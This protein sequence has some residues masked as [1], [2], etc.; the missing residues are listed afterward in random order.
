MIM[1]TTMPRANLP[2]TVDNLLRCLG[3]GTPLIFAY[4]PDDLDDA[5]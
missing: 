2:T 4:F 1:I 3:Y 5:I